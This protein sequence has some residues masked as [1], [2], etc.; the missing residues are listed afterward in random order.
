MHFMDDW[1]AG[2]DNE[3]EEYILDTKVVLNNSTGTHQAK[4]DIVEDGFNS[5]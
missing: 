3:W 4:F 2:T 5:Q 1:K